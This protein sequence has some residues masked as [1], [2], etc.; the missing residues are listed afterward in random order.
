M[1]PRDYHQKCKRLQAAEDAWAHDW[2]KTKGKEVMR[3]ISRIHWLVRLLAISLPRLE[4]SH[5][6]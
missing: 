4:G 1:F 2:A 3:F 6:H 5:P